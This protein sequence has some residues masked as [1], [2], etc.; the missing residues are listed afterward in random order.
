MLDVD[1]K[2]VLQRVKQVGNYAENHDRKRSAARHERGVN[3][4]WKDAA[5]NAP[6]DAF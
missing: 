6:P 1:A 5:A 3:K 2:V 4:L